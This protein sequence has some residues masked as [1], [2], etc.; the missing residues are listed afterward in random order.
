MFIS[1]PYG[2]ILETHIIICIFLSHIIQRIPGNR[3]IHFF[4]FFLLYNIDYYISIDSPECPL[5]EY[6]VGSIL[7][8]SIRFF[9]SI[10]NYDL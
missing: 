4:D 9:L 8:Y 10:T 7:A 2:H 6:L 5:Q 1:W 3:K